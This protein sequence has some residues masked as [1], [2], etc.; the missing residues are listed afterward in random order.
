MRD[1]DEYDV[2]QRSGVVYRINPPDA[3]GEDPNLR[4]DCIGRQH[5]KFYWVEL[6]GANGNVGIGVPNPT[7]ALDVAGDI[8]ASGRG[9]A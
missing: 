9:R 2:L 4:N 6:A 1:Q 3:P 8:H 7:A 5:V